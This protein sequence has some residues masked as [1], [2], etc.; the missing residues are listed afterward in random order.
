MNKILCCLIFGLIFLSCST[1]L[2]DKAKKLIKNHLHE[3][4][5][6]EKSYES[7]SYGGLD[8]VFTTISDN[9]TYIMSIA[10][11]EFYS[12]KSDK[13]MEDFNLY[14]DLYSDTYKR[15]AI[16]SLANAREYLDSMKVY[17]PILDSIK[18]NFMP[19]FKGWSMKHSYRAN[20][21]SGNKIIGHFRFYFDIGLTEIVDTKD[22]G[23]NSKE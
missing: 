8:S 15:K 14:I 7:V 21:A 17:A 1:S 18:D 6:D 9:D 19:E 16:K 22:I 2:E 4:L 23:E 13:S 12:D 11:Y 20:N 3:T 5:H 10:K